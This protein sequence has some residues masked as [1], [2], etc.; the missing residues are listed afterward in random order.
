M[1]YDRF[2]VQTSDFFGQRVDV[3][4]AS[5]ADFV[6]NALENLADAEALIG[7]RGRGTSYRPFTLVE[8]LRRD[9]EALYRAK[10]Q[11]LQQRLKDLQ[12]Q[13]QAIEQRGAGQRAAPAAKSC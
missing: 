10:E 3:P 5:N 12:S 4:T 7:L 1:L 8:A 11:E 2:W 13:L 9:A 6:V